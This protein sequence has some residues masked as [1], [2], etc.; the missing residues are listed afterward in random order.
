MDSDQLIPW[1]P[2]SFGFP[3]QLVFVNAPNPVD[4][5]FAG[6]QVT[7]EHGTREGSKMV[8]LLLFISL[9]TAR[10]LILDQL[11]GW[12]NYNETAK[13]L[14]YDGLDKS[15]ATLETILR[16]QGPFDGILGFSQGGFV[17]FLCGGILYKRWFPKVKA[18]WQ[19]TVVSN[20]GISIP[21]TSS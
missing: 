7:T 14:K 12:W 20:P 8:C 10:V 16:E 9:L 11:R 1:L 21:H 4:G 6:L 2:F 3:T 13:G 15:F 18:Y 19:K 5:E 17:H